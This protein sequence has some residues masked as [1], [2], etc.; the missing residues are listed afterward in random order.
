[1]T[2]DSWV[3]S[4]LQVQLCRRYLW[5][6][7]TW[8]KMRPAYVVQLGATN[9]W[10]DSICRWQSASTL[11][12]L[13]SY[14]KAALCESG[15]IRCMQNLLP[16]SFF[17]LRNSISSNIGVCFQHS[18]SKPVVEQPWSGDHPHVLFKPAS[19]CYE[20]EHGWILEQII[21]G[22][23]RSVNGFSFSALPLKI[24]ICSFYPQLSRSS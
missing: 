9:R 23:R 24:L 16:H 17:L 13:D 12:P 5:R 7:R 1:M 2:L 20:V 21:S 11:S 4:H 6:V 10:A 15:R 14:V 22:W 18:T 3:C 8:A 19:K